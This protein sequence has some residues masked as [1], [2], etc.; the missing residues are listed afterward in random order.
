MGRPKFLDLRQPEG[1]RFALNVSD[2][3]IRKW[4]DNC[5]VITVVLGTHR[6]QQAASFEHRLVFGRAVLGR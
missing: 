5:V 6:D 2:A 1:M 4:L 3:D